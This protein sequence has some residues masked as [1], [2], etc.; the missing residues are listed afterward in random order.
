VAIDLVY[1]PP[2]T[3]FLRAARARGMRCTNGLGM[4]V[5]QGALAFELW[6]G[7]PA[8]LGPMLAALRGKG[9]T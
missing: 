7:Q 5:R 9:V 4:L 1:A 3:P 2:E 8:P 6:L